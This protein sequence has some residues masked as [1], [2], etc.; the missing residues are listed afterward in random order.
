MSD[1]TLLKSK[2]VSQKE[3]D[4]CS[5]HGYDIYNTYLG[6]GAVGRVFLGR[7]RPEK[8]RKNEK[9]KII[10]EAGKRLQVSIKFYAMP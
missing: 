10:H 9:L 8:I 3:K 4:A 6:G 7:A 1:E 2:S 5:A